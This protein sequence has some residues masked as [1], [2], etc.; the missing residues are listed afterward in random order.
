MTISSERQHPKMETKAKTN[1]RQNAHREINSDQGQRTTGLGL[2]P[3][4]PM[5]DTYPWLG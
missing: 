5:I 4:D 1:V 2:E 3:A